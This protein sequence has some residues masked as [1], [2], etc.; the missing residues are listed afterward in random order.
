MM[1]PSQLDVMPKET[2]TSAI[3]FPEGG[4]PADEKNIGDEEVTNEDQG[5]EAQT[6]P[7]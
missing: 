6:A 7:K 2:D 1:Q 5:Q 4:A 3:T